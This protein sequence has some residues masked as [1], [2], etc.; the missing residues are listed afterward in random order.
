[1]AL[2]ILLEQVAPASRT[3]PRIREMLLDSATADL[4]P[5]FARRQWKCSDSDFLK[6]SPALLLASRLLTSP[7]SMHYWHAMLFGP[8]RIEIVESVA[9]TVFSCAHDDRIPLIEAEAQKVHQAL[10]QLTNHIT[11]SIADVEGCHGVT[12]AGRNIGPHTLG[13]EASTTLNAGH[14]RGLN[15]STT[16]EL[17]RTWTTVAVTMCHE[18]AHAMNLCYW[19]APFLYPHPEPFFDDGVHELGIVHNHICGYKLVSEQ[20]W[21]WTRYTLGGTVDT[22]DGL[23]LRIDEVPSRRN[24]DADFQITVGWGG[25]ITCGCRAGIGPGVADDTWVESLFMKSFWDTEVPSTNGMALMAV[26]KK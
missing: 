19:G 18:V 22:L 1:M 26:R 7:K 20:G 12:R 2:Q 4:H 9:L 17:L 6:I 10:E 8:R 24:L 23:E 11:L 25:A 14:V 3:H 16:H 15:F 13:V 5:I 21:N